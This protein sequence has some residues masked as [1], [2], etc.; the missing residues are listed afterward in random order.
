[1]ECIKDTY[2]NPENFGSPNASLENN[3]KKKPW[4]NLPKVAKD[5]SDIFGD[6][7]ISLENNS[8][9]LVR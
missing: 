4:D 5:K 3:C 7:S 1:M 6:S 2:D 9:K 8:K